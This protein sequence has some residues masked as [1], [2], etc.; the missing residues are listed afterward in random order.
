MPTPSVR[1]LSLQ[2]LESPSACSFAPR[3]SCQPKSPRS[4]GSES[5]RGFKRSLCQ[6]E[7]QMSPSFL[8]S[9]ALVRD[10]RV[11]KVDTS[12]E[13]IDGRSPVGTDLRV[14]DCVVPKCFLDQNRGHLG[15]E[16]RRLPGTDQHSDG[17]VAAWHWNRCPQIH[18]PW[19]S[20]MYFRSPTAIASSRQTPEPKLPTKCTQRGLTSP[21]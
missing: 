11:V 8:L 2:W 15:Q 3:H 17:E 20:W 10:A 19:L 12:S 7:E 16:L 1:D 6:L 14:L 21:P 13:S 4:H 9:A 5:P 18:Q